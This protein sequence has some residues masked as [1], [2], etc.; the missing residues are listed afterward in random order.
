M[1]QRVLRRVADSI[2]GPLYVYLLDKVQERCRQLRHA[3]RASDPLIL[4]AMKANSNKAVLQTVLSGVDGLE[5]VSI[6]EVLLAMKLGAQRILFTNVNVAPAEVSAVCTLARSCAASGKELWVNCDS[7]Q[8]INELPEGCQAFL[9]VNGPLGAGHHAHV[10][11][12]GPDSKFGV[13][14]ADVR[15]ALALAKVR[16]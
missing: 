1:E 3:L 14:H 10:V 6:G 7:L 12:C 2:G 16:W 15:A 11:T 13:F 8:A 5:C 9:R 4:F